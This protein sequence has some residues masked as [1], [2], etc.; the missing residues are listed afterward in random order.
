MRKSRILLASLVVLGLTGTANGYL[1]IVSPRCE[2]AREALGLRRAEPRFTRPVS[3]NEDGRAVSE[4]RV[5][6]DRK[7]V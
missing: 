6:R 1:S 3:G 5:L 2:G 7:V 4:V